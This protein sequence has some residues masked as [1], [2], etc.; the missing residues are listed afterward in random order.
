MGT[1]DQDLV[2]QATSGDRQAL[3]G[4]LEEHA[5]A[6]CRRLAGKIPRRWQ[7]VLSMDDVMQQTCADA[8]LSIGRFEPH[9]EG[10]FGAWLFTIAKRNLLNALEM[11]EAEKRGKGRRRIEPIG[12]EDSFVA[13][14]DLL[15]AGLTTPSRHAAQSEACGM[16][17]QAIQ[18]LPET[19]RKAVQMYD[20]EGRPVEEVAQALKRSPGSVHMIRTRAHRRLQAIM[21]SMSKFFST[22]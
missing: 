14:Y 12:R 7:S 1:S 9:G 16:L 6:V 8:F 18:H 17:E 11:L 15:S 3:V 10:S 22:A 4:L 21:G 2:R 20:I 19:Y 5:P 13:L